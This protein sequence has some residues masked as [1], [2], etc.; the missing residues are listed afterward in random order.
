MQKSGLSVQGG[1]LFTEVKIYCT[2]TIIGTRPSGLYR[3]VVLG[4]KWS[5]WYVSLY[6]HYWDTTIGKWSL[7]FIE[8]WSLDTSGLYCMFHCKSTIGTRPS[9][10]YREVVPGYKW[11]LWQVLLY[12]G[13][14]ILYSVDSAVLTSD[15]STNR[16]AAISDLQ[17]HNNLSN[18]LATVNKQV[19]STCVR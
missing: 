16:G 2:S 3:E 18:H 4:Y 6:K 12:T 17:Q 15:I 14:R 19:H 13:N 8:R 10:I 5:L 7:Y 11:S 1:G 9:G